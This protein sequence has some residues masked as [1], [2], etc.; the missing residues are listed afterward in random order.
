MSV[1]QEK[2]RYKSDQAFSICAPE[3]FAPRDWEHGEV[4]RIAVDKVLVVTNGPARRLTFAN[5]DRHAAETIAVEELR[6]APLGLRIR[7]SPQRCPGRVPHRARRPL[8]NY[9]EMV[10]E[11]H[12]EQQERNKRR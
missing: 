1:S 11:D 5:F 3:C 12:V 6:A 10:L 7:P 4:G 9:V 8:A 2:L